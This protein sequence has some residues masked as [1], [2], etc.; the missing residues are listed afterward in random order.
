LV[1]PKYSDIDESGADRMQYP[2][3]WKLVEAQFDQEFE[4]HI[5]PLFKS[6]SNFCLSDFLVLEKWIDYAKGIGDPTAE[7]FSGL[8]VKYDDIFS[9]AK[10]R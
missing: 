3:K 10:A 8:Q 2:S 5:E 7:L 6:L 9:L 1:F 4:N